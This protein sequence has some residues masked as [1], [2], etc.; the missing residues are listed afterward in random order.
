MRPRT[1]GAAAVLVAA[2]LLAAPA[3]GMDDNTADTQVT[4]GYDAF[5]P[6]ETDVLAGTSV[7]W[8]ND[9]AR[10]HTVTADD[11]SFDS[12]RL[13]AQTTYRH[14]FDAEADVLYHC[15]VHPA[16]RGV[17][18]VR[19]I[20]L[21]APAVPAGPGRSYPLR[22]RTSLPAGTPIT[23]ESDT[24][25]GF[26]P[27]ATTTATA[28]GTFAASVVPSTTGAYRATAGDAASPAVTL[29]VLDHTVTVRVRRGRVT[30]HV[31]PAEPGGHVVLQLRLRDRFGWFPVAVATLDRNSD[32]VLRTTVRRRTPA[33]VRYTLPDDA[34]PLAESRTIHVTR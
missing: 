25:A 8:T 4:V 22:G 2:C 23:I 10:A 21:D 18:H 12:G 30:A 27:A 24:G 17:L 33:R 15:T 11:D 6:P 31:A 9:S 3:A 26:A 20:L 14:A 19:R 1:A 13:T 16:M 28:D 34:T 7:T 29:I 32:A 5:K